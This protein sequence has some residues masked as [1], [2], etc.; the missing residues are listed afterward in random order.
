METVRPQ[1]V[2]FDYGPSDH[3]SSTNYKFQHVSFTTRPLYSAAEYQQLILHASYRMEP[4]DYVKMMQDLQEAGVLS[5]YHERQYKAEKDTD[6][7]IQ[8]LV[9]NQL[10]QHK[11]EK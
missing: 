6:N 9:D 10:I 8:I 11:K 1:T 2:E 3:A 4:Q 5:T 7:A